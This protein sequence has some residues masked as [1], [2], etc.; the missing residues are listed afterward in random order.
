MITSRAVF[1]LHYCITGVSSRRH[2]ATRDYAETL[3]HRGT[4]RS[5][6]EL[7]R[8]IRD[9]IDGWNGR[10]HPFVWTR[11][12]TKSSPKPTVK[13][14]QTRTTRT[15]ECDPPPPSPHIGPPSISTS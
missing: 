3:I 2:A 14:L 9:F 6:R 7:T 4:F 5:V 15:T 8:K 1:A 13:Q 11:P 12:P 10:A